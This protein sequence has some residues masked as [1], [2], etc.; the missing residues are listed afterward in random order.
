MGI[1]PKQ[2]CQVVEEPRLGCHEQETFCCVLNESAKC[3]V[4]KY[5]GIYPKQPCQVVE[6]PRL[7]C[8]EQETFFCVLNE[9][10]M[11]G[12]IWGYT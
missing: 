9:S 2:L 1:Y 10:D 12:N 8:H 4:R 6:G 11:S 5:L 3:S 7:G